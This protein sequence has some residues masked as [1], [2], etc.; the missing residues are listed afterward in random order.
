MERN[1][2]I[3]K[4]AIKKA[5][6]WAIAVF[7]AFIAFIPYIPIGNFGFSAD[8]FL[9]LLIILIGLAALFFLKF[10]NFGFTV[11]KTPFLYPLLA[12]ILAGVLS[13]VYNIINIENS[14]DFFSMI[15]KGPARYFFTL[16]FLILAYYF[17]ESKKQVETV[18]AILIFASVLESAFAIGAFLLSW[19]GLF[20]IG[21]ATSRSYSV[22][23]GIVSG[24]AN[25]TFG[26]VLENFVGSNLLAAYLII[27]IPISISFFII[28]KKLWQKFLIGLAIILQ[29]VCLCLTYTRTSIVYLIFVL[30][31]FAWA[32]KEKKIQREFV[33]SIVVVALIFSLFIPGLAQRFIQDSTNRLDIWKSAALVVKEY[34]VWGTGPGRFL[35]ELSSGIIRYEVFTFDTEVLTPHNFFLYSWATLG[36]FGLLAVLWICWR[37]AK[38]LRAGFEKCV[39]FRERVIF[40]GIMSGCLGFFFQNFTNNFLFVPTVATYFWLLYALGVKYGEDVNQKLGNFLS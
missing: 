35:E 5:A 31:F 16:L 6:F 12:L 20:N 1:S 10:E 33:Y 25:G 21:I 36:I 23:D 40:A 37:A 22:L 9:F 39:N 19:Q 38:D 13:S 32:L 3:R 11:K 15:A 14:V 34:P 7:S 26:S 2:Q 30:F 28:S 27:L 8:D 4:Q 24:R 17:I 18:L 29:T